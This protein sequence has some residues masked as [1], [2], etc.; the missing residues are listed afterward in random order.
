MR[1]LFAQ[2][3]EGESDG[4]DL[5]GEARV[6]KDIWSA[7]QGVGGIHDIPTTAELAGRIV[8]E[9]REALEAAGAEAKTWSAG[10]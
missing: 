2:A 5:E 8:R 9:H 1:I 3:D 10:V 6:W 7:G 4:M